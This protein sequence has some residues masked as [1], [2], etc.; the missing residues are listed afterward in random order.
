MAKSTTS[1]G[2][3]YNGLSRREVSL[4]AEWE[5]ARRSSITI[6]DIRASVG[7]SAARDVARDLVRKR[8]LQRL[9]P[10]RYL[11]R[12][13][14][15]IGRPSAPS[16]AVALE[17]LLRDERH[18]L[19]GLW[20]LSFHGLTE[21]RYE[22][23]FDAFVTHRLAARSL[24]FARVRFHVLERRAFDYG[25]TT[26]PIEGV[27]VHISDVERTILDALD[28]PRLFLGIGRGVELTKSHLSHLDRKRLVAHAVAGSKSSTCQRLGVL[29]QRAGMSQPSLAKLRMRARETTSLLS[30][31][32]DTPRRGAV[33][34]DWNVV[35][36]DA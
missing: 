17:G 27:D 3:I 25:V 28:H 34:R 9:R 1:D 32:P 10:G 8:A 33:N 26:S 4:L 12:P 31:N 35:E 21:Q 15:T 5:R 23:R 24:G 14:R 30:M 22:S 16:T 11:L 20:A 36:N 18:Y 29:L 2:F 13:F 7:A 19:G 6:A